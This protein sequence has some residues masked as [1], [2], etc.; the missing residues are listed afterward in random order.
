M[1][2]AMLLEL[3]AGPN[4]ATFTTLLPDG[5][6]QSSVMWF[7]VIEDFVVIN[8][9][10]HRLKYRNVQR[11]PRVALVVWD[12]ANPYRYVE[13]RGRVVRTEAGE[14][15]RTHIDAVSERYTGG[16]YSNPITSQRVMLFI[17]PER[18]RRQG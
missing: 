7:D 17:T 2:D 15:A 1:V 5:S 12:H 13:V 11:D 9:E 14:R 10:T 18:Q 4:F 6:P 16:P 8:T 3:A